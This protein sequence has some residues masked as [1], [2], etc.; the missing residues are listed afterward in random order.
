MGFSDYRSGF[1]FEIKISILDPTDLE[2]LKRL[3][4]MKKIFS[5]DNSVSPIGASVFC[6]SFVGFLRVSPKF[7]VCTINIYY[8]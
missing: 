3:Q 2:N 4:K 5:W 6:I 7:Q 1:L 8:V